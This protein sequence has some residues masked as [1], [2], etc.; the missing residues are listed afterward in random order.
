MKNKTLAFGALCSIIF[1]DGVGLGIIFP[2]LV[3]LFLDPTVSILPPGTSALW[4]QIGYGV[5]LSVFPLGIFFS[6]PLLG[7][8]SDGW[9]RK[10]I[11]RIAVFGVGFAYF[12]SAVAVLIHS[13]SLLIFS[14]LFS[15]LLSGSQP[16]AQAAAM[17]MSEPHEKAQHL[18]LIF[19]FSSVGFIIGPLLGSGF[20]NP[21]L[22]PW[23]NESTPLFVAAFA[24]FACGY[25]LRY[26]KE[27]LATS[28]SVR[29]N[30]WRG[31]VVLQEAWQQRSIRLLLIVLLFY[32]LAW[33]GFFQGV[34]IY[35]A[36]QHG[37][38]SAGIGYYSS[39]IGVGFGTAFLGA[40]NYFSLRFDPK[41]IVLITLLVATGC[42]VLIDV[43]H[44]T[45]A[46]WLVAAPLGFCIAHIY[47][48]LSTIGSNQVA[49]THQGWFMG[50]VMTVMAL[51][52]F[53]SPL[54]N[55]VLFSVSL[56]APLLFSAVMLFMS[57][58]FYKVWLQDSP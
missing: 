55:S 40:I 27:T 38:T 49:K 13:I 30:P 52:W 45:T 4:R 10:R 2:L 25:L 8:L 57:L 16:I 56:L 58:W 12:L 5:T 26:F 36:K 6:A 53:A 7:D 21:H 20:S 31:L 17:D 22:V 29:L 32:Q 9:G 15:G 46:L 47:V 37:F 44:S 1:L 41:K 11:L 54:I 18:S 50:A 3:P 42:I 19:F 14:R 34:P 39:L 33:S 48:L 28:R 24:S 35:L 51:A 23:F 43:W